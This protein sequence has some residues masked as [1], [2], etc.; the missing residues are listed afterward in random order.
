VK[1]SDAKTSVC[2]LSASRAI[3]AGPYPDVTRRAGYVV[4]VLEPDKGWCVAGNPRWS[5]VPPLLSNDPRG[6]WDY[7]VA[8]ETGDYTTINLA[9]GVRLGHWDLQMHI[10]NLTDCSVASYVSQN[11]EYPSAYRLR[12][13]INARVC[14]MS[15]GQ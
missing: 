13:R 8:T 12:P 15:S 1:K 6:I 7:P 3:H 10:Q 11:V 4:I 2:K 5:D 14:D 9:A